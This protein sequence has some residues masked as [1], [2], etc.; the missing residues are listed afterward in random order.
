[1]FVTSYVHEYHYLLDFQK[2][3]LAPE[4]PAMPEKPSFLFD[5][6]LW[7]SIGSRQ[8]RVRFADTYDEGRF[9]GRVITCPSTHTGP[10]GQMENGLVA[11]EA[12]NKKSKWV[13]V[14]VDAKYLLHL[15]PVSKNANCVPLNGDH[16]GQVLN[17]LKIN[18]AVK[19]ASVVSLSSNSGK[20][21]E[22]LDN[23]CVV[24]NPRSDR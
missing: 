23:L 8:I 11:L 4:Q 17:V 10:Q 22:D 20:W 3:L 21:E 16:R 18:K 7:A 12:T 2:W 14:V 13:A 24:E 9:Y 1:M 6:T 19:T 5:D 15:P